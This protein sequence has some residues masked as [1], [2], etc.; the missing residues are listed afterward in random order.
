MALSIQ[1]LVGG[2]NQFSVKTKKSLGGLSLRRG[3]GGGALM[4]RPLKKLLLR[5]PQKT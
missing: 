3:G 2:K 1:K 5:L 4:A